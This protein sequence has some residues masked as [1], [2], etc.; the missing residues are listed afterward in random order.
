MSA[1]ASRL[2][3][4]ASLPADNDRALLIGR[5]WLPDVQGPAVVRVTADGVFDLSQVASTVTGLLDLRDAAAAVRDTGKLPR[6]ADTASVLA[7]SAAPE[8]P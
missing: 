8:M 7:N 3:V 1:I 2:T 4:A 5:A 6:I